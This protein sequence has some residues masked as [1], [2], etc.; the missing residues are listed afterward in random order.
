MGTRIDQ[1]GNIPSRQEEDPLM[2]QR[3]NQI[4]QGGMGRQ[5]SRHRGDRPG[6]QSAALG[7]SDIS[8]GSYMRVNKAGQLIANKV[9]AATQSTLTAG[10]TVEALQG[11]IEE[12][13]ITLNGLIS[14]LQAA[15]LMER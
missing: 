8:T 3:R 4:G 1:H 11:N 14:A 10:N 7:A 13:Q 15:K 9:K 12:L 6:K 2:A 5:M